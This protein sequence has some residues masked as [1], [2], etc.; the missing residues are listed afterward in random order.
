MHTVTRRRQR[1]NRNILN[2]QKLDEAK[3]IGLITFESKLEYINKLDW[4]IIRKLHLFIS[5]MVL[6]FLYNYNIKNA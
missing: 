4:N 6:L 1:K 5:L 2:L 3:F